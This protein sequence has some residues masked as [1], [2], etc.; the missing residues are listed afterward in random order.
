MSL[1]MYDNMENGPNHYQLLR[2]TRDTPIAAIKK[3]YRNL[4]LGKAGSFLLRSS[5]L[6]LIET[7]RLA[8]EFHPDKNKD[9]SA[10]DTFT[11]IKHAFDVITDKDKRREY[12]RL[13][14]HGVAVLAQTVVDYR[15]I[16]LQLI[17]YYASSGIFAF[18]MTFSEPTGDAFQICLF[19]LAGNLS[20]S[21]LDRVVHGADR[22]FLVDAWQ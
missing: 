11:K 1:Q 21:C 13:G 12:N 9:P 6:Q 19:G 10:A 20:R 17:V 8:A 2:V 16:V 5:V 4:S 22:N 3:S 14:E 15:Y 18:L 7:L